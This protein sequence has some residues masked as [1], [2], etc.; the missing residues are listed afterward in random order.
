MSERVRFPA[1]VGGQSLIG[2]DRKRP[3]SWGN[4]FWLSNKGPRVV[5]M[6]AENMKY[7]VETGVLF[8]EMIEG[9]LFSNGPDWEYQKWFVVDDAR[10]PEEYL[11]NKFCFTG[12]MTPPLD[13][14]TEMY[15]IHGDPTGELEEWTDPVSYYR[16]RGSEYD[17][18]TGI[19]TT[20][21]NSTPR[22]IKLNMGYRVDPYKD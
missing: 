11:Y 5:N 7:L 22:E 19:I 15:S 10:V 3:T 14:A 18:K 12:G 9:V 17:P 6:W 8:D 20:R 16:K 13:I 21:V 1:R 4:Y 2:V